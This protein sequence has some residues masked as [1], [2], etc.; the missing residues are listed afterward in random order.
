MPPNTSPRF[1]QVSI[2]CGCCLS[3][4]IKQT[5]KKKKK[6]GKEKESKEEGQG[7]RPVNGLFIVFVL[8][9]CGGGRKKKKR[10]GGKQDGN[11]L[12]VHR[13]LPLINST[14]SRKREEKK[15]KREEEKGG[16]GRPTVGPEDALV[17]SSWDLCCILAKN[18]RKG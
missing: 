3:F 11:D 4:S 17:I 6:G 13:F 15:K 1:S 12:A 14:S 18:K 2:P 16:R 5:R 7:E 10:G 8:S 9:G